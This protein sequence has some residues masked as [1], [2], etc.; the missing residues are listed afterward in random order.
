LRL[1]F[2]ALRDLRR[3][4]D[5]FLRP[6]FFL[7]APDFFTPCLHL[8]A[9]RLLR[10][11]LDA[12]RLLR[13]DLPLDLPLDLD[14]LRLL[15]L[16]LPLD[17][18]LDLRL[19]LPLDLRLDLDALRLL[20]LDLDFLFLH[21]PVSRLRTFPSGQGALRLLRLDLDALRLLRLLLPLDLDALRLF[22]R[23]LEPLRDLRRDF[24][25]IDIST[26]AFPNLAF[27]LDFLRPE[28][29]TPFALAS[30][31]NSAKVNECDL[32]IYYNTN[33]ILI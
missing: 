21:L 13:L 3:L 27:K 33:I 20:R 6:G 26:P 10:L 9:L 5:P 14:A 30:F 11:D 28:N 29:A 32:T 12:L 22:R 23:L 19:D 7:Q 2:D 25:I 17:L 8:D 24:A 18:R 16:L 15:R 1:D 31:C 4:L